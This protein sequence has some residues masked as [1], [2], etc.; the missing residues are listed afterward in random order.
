MRP[1]IIR[2]LFFVLLAVS[3]LYL[4]AQEMTRLIDSLLKVYA[5]PAS[6]EIKAEKAGV[7]SHYY[8]AVDPQKA[9]TW[10]KK[11]LEDAELSRNR[12]AM[13]KANIDN[14]VRLGMV[15]GKKENI[16]SAIGFFEESYKI[17]RKNNLQE[18]MGRSLI[19]LSGMNRQVPD[20]DK[21]LNQASQAVSVLSA[22]GNDSLQCLALLAVGAAYV[23]KDDKLMGLKNYFDATVLAEKTKN[24]ILLRSCYSRLSGFYQMVEN[25]DKSLDY[26]FKMMD[27]SQQDK[28][29]DMKYARVNDLK[30]VGDIYLQKK[31]YDLAAVFYERSIHTADS[32]KFNQLK[33]QGYLGLINLYL[34][35]DEPKK[36]K[37]FFDS[38][39][40]LKSYLRLYGMEIVVNQAYGYI[41]GKMGKNDSADYHFKKALPFFESQVNSNSKMSFYN[42]YGMHLV[43]SGRL[44]NGIE[45]LLA[46][47]AVAK[48]NKNLE[49]MSE[50]AKNLDS[51]YRQLGDYKQALHYSGLARNYQDSLDKLGKEDELL[52]L[53][54]TDEENRK[55]RL[56]KEDKEKIEKRNRIQYMAIIIAIATVFMILVLLGFLRV[57][58]TSIRIIGFFAFLMFFEF[59]F[60]VF[61]KTI[62]GITH[63]EP[64]KD[65]AMMILIAAILVPLHHWAEHKL[66]HYLS[67][68]HMLRLRNSS[69]EWWKGIFGKSAE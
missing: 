19:F 31:N 22:T 68:Q 38:S 5:S 46:A 24:S 58:V 64:W 21:A 54:I 42:Q 44:Q 48:E 3:P 26:A 69:K 20:A 65:L 60:L 33:F 45:M 6:L 14:G 67:S 17:A 34:E 53:Q 57:S 16:T 56:L 49:A 11:A 59:I 7:L 15:T 2:I 35:S 36:A 28:V 50:L 12:K 61:K 23:S 18:E 30:L 4:C 29:P 47:N 66:I 52:Q 32:I 40:E 37:T 39:S 41:F 51:S 43:K 8:M 62:Y 63:G 9:E 1:V 25:Y 13:A 10:G 27:I 55:E